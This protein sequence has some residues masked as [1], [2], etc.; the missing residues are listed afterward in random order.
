MKTLKMVNGNIYVGKEKIS[1][2]IFDEELFEYK[3]IDREEFI[4]DLIDWISE[5]KTSSKELMKSDLKMLMSLDDECMFS[6]IS[7]NY[8][9]GFNDKE[10]QETCR[11]L[12]E[13]NKN[14]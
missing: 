5:C 12:L 14:I 8:Y 4:D 9:I 3:V 10:F 6:S 13:L 7:T 2:K 11:D 1:E